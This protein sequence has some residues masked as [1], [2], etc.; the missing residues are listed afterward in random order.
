MNRGRSLADRPRQG[1]HRD[2]VGVQLGD[3]LM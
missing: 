2:S 3:H 1:D